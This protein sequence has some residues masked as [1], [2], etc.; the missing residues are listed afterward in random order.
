MTTIK[1]GDTNTDYYEW[2]DRLE[3]KLDEAL[4]KNKK[5]K[6]HEKR[7]RKYDNLSD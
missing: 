4:N 2:L 5:E 3:K 7:Q 6:R 1:G